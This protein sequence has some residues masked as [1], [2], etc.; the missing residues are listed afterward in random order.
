MLLS[1]GT[2]AN[3]LVTFNAGQAQPTYL[4]DSTP[5]GSWASDSQQLQPDGSEGNSLSDWSEGDGEG[6]VASRLATAEA[7]KDDSH[8]P[9]VAGLVFGGKPSPTCDLAGSSPPTPGRL[10]E[11]AAGSSNA[12]ASEHAAVLDRRRQLAALVPP[13]RESPYRQD[14]LAVW[15][16]ARRSGGHPARLLNPQLSFTQMELLQQVGK[17]TV[18]STPS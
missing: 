4:S 12:H 7:T 16:A 8:P 11:L 13:P 3:D 9:G 6:E 2:R 15:L 5:S 18:G 1:P 17:R 10:S 14:S